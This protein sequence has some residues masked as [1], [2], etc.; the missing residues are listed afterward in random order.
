MHLFMYLSLDK[1]KNGFSTGGI[2][3]V[4]AGVGVM[5]CIVVGVATRKKKKGNCKCLYMTIKEISPVV[6]S[7]VSFWQ[8]VPQ[9]SSKSS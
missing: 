1:K 3:G 6:V 5:M 4:A 2:I 8:D 9:S 7:Q